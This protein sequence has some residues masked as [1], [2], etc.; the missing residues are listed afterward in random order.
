MCIR[1]RYVDHAPVALEEHLGHACGG[2]EVPVDLE[3]RVGVPQVVE[4]A[5]LQ[6]L[7][8]HLVGVVPVE[9]AS[10]EVDLPRL[11]PAGTPVTS[12]PERHLGRLGQLRARGDG[13]T[14]WSKAWK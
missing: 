2:T 12:R 4:G 3:R 9:Q 6:L 8:E 1:D 11:A 7:G 14:G 10:P 13:G 5:L